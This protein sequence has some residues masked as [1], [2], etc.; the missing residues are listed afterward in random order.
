MDFGNIYGSN[1]SFGGKEKLRFFKIIIILFVLVSIGRLA[2]L[3]IIEGSSY[4]Y[5]S[6]TQAIKKLI[7]EPFR[8]NMFD[9]NKELIVHNEPSFSVTLT[10]NDFKVEALPVL[11]SILPLDTLE[12][13]ETYAVK[14]G[15]DD[16]RNNIIPHILDLIKIDTN[17]ISKRIVKKKNYGRF[18]PVKIYKDADFDEISRVEEFRDYLPGVEVIVESKRLYEFEGTMAHMLGYTRE[19]SKS[20]LERYQYYRPGDAIGKRG[21]EKTYETLL[22]GQPGVQFVAVNATGRKIA[23]FEQGKK[24]ISAVN[25]HDLYLGIHKKAQE[26][27]EKLLEGNRGTVVAINPKNGELIVLAAKPDYNPRDFTGKV[28]NQLY[29]SLMNDPGKPMFNRAIQ[30]QY[31]PGS[32]WKMLVALAGLQEGIIN[33]N[34]TYYCGGAFAYGGRAPKCHG[35]HGQTN[36]RKAIHASCNVFFYQL[37]LKLGMENFEKYGHMFGFGELTH[38]DLPGEYAGIM[39]TM[40]WLNASKY[41]G[42]S[43]GKLLNYGIGQGEISVTPIQMAVYCA[44]LANKGTVLQPHIVSRVHNAEAKKY[45]DLDYSSRHVG[46]AEKYFD[47]IHQGMYDVVNTPGG[48]ASQARIPEVKVCGK[49]GTAQNPHGRDHAWFICFAPLEDPQIAMCVMVE[50]SGFG[51]SV[52]A[53]IARQVLEAFFGIERKPKTD[54]IPSLQSIDSSLYKMT[55]LNGDE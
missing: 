35:A 28:S 16:F 9:R 1:N 14:F 48:T 24:D 18:T 45:M 23:N 51:G 47:I 30:S 26:V 44:A 2:Q 10:P 42:F 46:I 5:V 25:G 43:K 21:I 19:I 4:K 22:R 54:S 39:P 13:I 17:G 31:S 12:I 27:A 20:E 34:T 29:T 40:E 37:G 7:I 55:F 15:L 38:I 50:N 52:A 41:R 32:T 53:P 3:Q 8:G 6:E 11:F 36:V 33:E 49:T